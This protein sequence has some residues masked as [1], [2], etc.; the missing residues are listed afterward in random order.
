MNEISFFPAF[1]KILFALAV[2]LG[3]MVAAA[4]LLRRFTNHP[5]SGYRDGSLI[6]IV[7]TRYIGPKSSILLVD[8]LGKGVVVGLSNGQMTLLTAIDDSQALEKM[9]TIGQQEPSNPVLVD[10][11]KRYTDRFKPLNGAQ[12]GREQR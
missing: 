8:V 12:K 1:L 3:L 11:L 2:V 7:S 6:Q 5:S 4:Y 9:R 10:F